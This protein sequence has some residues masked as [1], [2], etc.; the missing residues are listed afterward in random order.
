MALDADRIRDSFR[1]HRGKR[2]ILSQHPPFL[3]SVERRCKYHNSFRDLAKYVTPSNRLCPV[4]TGA[5]VGVLSQELNNLANAQ[6]KKL[7]TANG[8]SIPG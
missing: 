6:A 5:Q 1:L 2:S 4:D 8:T 3:L 7:R